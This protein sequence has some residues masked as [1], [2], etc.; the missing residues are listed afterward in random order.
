MKSFF[1]FDVIGTNDFSVDSGISLILRN[2]S[3][4]DGEHNYSIQQP[5]V[6]VLYI[7]LVLTLSLLLT[8]RF[9]CSKSP[10]QLMLDV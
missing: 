2:A 10:L 7:D 8:A 6:L 9:K 3:I 1:E 4:L 5:R